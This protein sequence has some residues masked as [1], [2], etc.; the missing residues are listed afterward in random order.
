MASTYLLNNDNEIIGTETLVEA[1]KYSQNDPKV[2]RNLYKVFINF[3]LQ[4]KSEEVFSKFKNEDK[5]SLEWEV[6]K[7]L[8]EIHSSKPVDMIISECSDRFELIQF[9]ED[10]ITHLT[11]RS[12]KEGSEEMR[13][14]LNDTLERFNL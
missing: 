12:E 14:L 11:T 6:C 8:R 4:S 9:D 13:S 5:N 3:G 1:M 7:Y 10:C 2:L